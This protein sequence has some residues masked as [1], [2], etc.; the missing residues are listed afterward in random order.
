MVEVIVSW[1][2][3]VAVDLKESQQQWITTADS[4]AKVFAVCYFLKIMQMTAT[5]IQLNNE[6][7]F[8][9]S[10]WWDPSE[11]TRIDR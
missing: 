3:L 5:P 11:L 1:I 2:I 9:L 10:V 8:D 4:M 6:M 7:E